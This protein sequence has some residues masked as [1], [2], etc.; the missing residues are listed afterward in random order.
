GFRSPSSSALE[1]ARVVAAIEGAALFTRLAARQVHAAARARDHVLR[2]RGVRGALALLHLRAEKAAE[3]EPDEEGD[4][5]EED[6]SSH[7]AVLLDFARRVYGKG[8]AAATLRRER[9]R[10][11]EAHAARR[12]KVRCAPAAAV[13]FGDQ[14]HD[15]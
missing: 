13:E 6:D 15:G 12:G 3:H 5:E 8:R 9:Q 2:A 7:V 11:F 14:P 1:A 10:D 4:D